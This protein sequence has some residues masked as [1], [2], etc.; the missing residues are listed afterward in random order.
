M[1]SS[2]VI[3]WLRE[4]FEEISKT[5]VTAVDV[6]R[7]L[8]HLTKVA[9]DAEDIDDR[10]SDEASW[11][12]HKLQIELDKSLEHQRTQNAWD[13]EMFRASLASGE[14]AIKTLLLVTGGTGAAM[15]AFLGHLVTAGK[16]YRVLVGPIAHGL[17]F[18]VAALLL[19][20]LIS[21]LR[22]IVQ[23]LFKHE[24][25]SRDAPDTASKFR[26]VGNIGTG[27]VVVLYATSVALLAAGIYEACSPFLSTSSIPGFGP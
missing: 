9:A 1:K 12:R 20:A 17:V 19:T 11:E 23:D 2:I 3:K 8:E 21:G 4:D 22:F 13:T 25:F 24:T 15:L 7:V 5:G 18:I 10:T 16:D 26:L 27:V 6:E 14:G